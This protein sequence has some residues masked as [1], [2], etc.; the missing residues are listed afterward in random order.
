M[1][2]RK[3]LDRVISGEVEIHVP[4][5]DPMVQV[6]EGANTFGGQI[7][8]LFAERNHYKALG[9]RL[10][11]QLEIAQR[12]LH[13]VA[14]ERESWRRLACNMIA[15]NGKLKATL[16][17]VESLFRNAR[18]TALE[19][20]HLASQLPQQQPEKTNGEDE[21]V[22]L[23]EHLVQHDLQPTPE[24][25]EELRTTLNKLPPN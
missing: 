1:S 16:D 6:V 9:E 14:Q 8:A 13:T 5:A 12:Q 22:D 24:D 4:P 10:M 7:N 20:D 19:V 18:N 15:A 3:K 11:C 21:A 17:G 25:I 2:L 23:D